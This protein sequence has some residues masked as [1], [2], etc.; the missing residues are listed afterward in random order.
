[1]RARLGTGVSAATQAVPG[2]CRHRKSFAANTISPA[3]ASPLFAVGLEC[4]S[5]RRIWTNMCKG[6]TEESQ[7]LAVV[8]VAST[9]APSLLECDDEAIDVSFKKLLFQSR[10]VASPRRDFLHDTLS[11]YV[12]RLRAAPFSELGGQKRAMIL[13]WR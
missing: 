8:K 9:R 1:V 4:D 3:A 12:Y 13:T 6:I 11:S 10:W 2:A 7:S 5:C